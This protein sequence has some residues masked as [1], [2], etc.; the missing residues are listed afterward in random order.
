MMHRVCLLIFL[1]VAH[2]V[3]LALSLFFDPF[4]AWGPARSLFSDTEAME[5]FPYQLLES[6]VQE[7]KLSTEY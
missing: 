4:T 2:R 3:G 7:K 6:Y 1:W 5:T